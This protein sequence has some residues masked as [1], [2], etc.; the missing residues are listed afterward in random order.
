MPRALVSGATGLV[1][2]HIVERLASDGWTV[3]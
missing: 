2:S 3:R 1:G